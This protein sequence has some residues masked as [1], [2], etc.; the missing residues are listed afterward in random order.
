MQ[1]MKAAL[2]AA[3]SAV[4]LLCCL[5]PSS[6]EESGRLA[7][8]VSIDGAIG[9]ASASYVKEALAKAS[10]RRAEVVLLRMNTPGGLNSS[11][12][13]IIADVLASP[14]PVIGYVAPSG[15][16][17]A[18]AGTYILY[19]T[20]IAAM[21]PGT[22]IGAA[23]PVQIG[24]PLPGL[25]SGTPDK[26]GKDKKDEP[27]DAM[28]AKVTNDAVAFIRSL[29]ELR[30]RNAD[31][32]EKAVREAATLSANGALEAHA[33]ELVA[34]DQAEL[35][36]QLDGRV[37]EVAGAR[38]QRLA[39]KDAVVEAVDPGRISRFLAVITDP[40]VAFIL[41]MVGIYGLIFEFMSPGAVAPGV[42][43]AICLLIGLYALNLLP[44]NYAGLALMLVGLVLLTI[45]AFNPTVV[46]GLG[47]IIAFVLGALM[48]FRAEAP[49]YQLSWWVIGITAAVFAGF[50]L[51]VLGSL[52]R[53][54]KAPAR[55]GAQAMRGLSAE[56]LD[57]N[58]NEGHVFAHGERWQAR[59][60][61]TFKP[62]DTV[63][64]AN[65]IDLT[66]L[67]RRT[68]AQTGEGGTS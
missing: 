39:T 16:H 54:G 32:A 55:V 50:A 52:R 8:I 6:A 43:G 44:I 46:I 25:P 28:T 21:A 7:L 68:P 13:E 1:T 45:E 3:I 34:R 4:A 42:V 66:L 15:A 63:E 23:T 67:I 31:W 19:A 10:E 51:V 30:G 12:R 37:V 26:D 33:I 58:G 2:V 65:V 47:G 62:G 20:H 38:T 57:W 36:R 48:L 56:V 24:G 22:N 64:V 60:A 29:A 11:M 18:S 49:G 61:E 27:K 35:L 5:L 41:L 59:G 40:N 17:A 14:I 9:P 53:I